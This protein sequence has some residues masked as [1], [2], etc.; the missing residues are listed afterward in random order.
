[1]EPNLQDL[2]SSKPSD[3]TMP[4]DAKAS[5]ESEPIW[6]SLSPTCAPPNEPRCFHSLQ[7]LQAHYAS[8]HAFV[9]PEEGCSCLFNSEH[10]LRLHRTEMHDTGAMRRK[11]AGESIYQCL[12]E[13]CGLI[14][15]SPAQRKKHLLGEHGFEQRFFFSVIK[16]GIGEHL[17]A[18]ATQSSDS[19]PTERLQPRASKPNKTSPTQQRS[20][21]RRQVH[22]NTVSNP[23][24]VNG[25]TSRSRAPQYASS[26]TSLT[27]SMSKVL[28]H[29]RDISAPGTTSMGRLQ[30]RVFTQ[31]RNASAPDMHVPVSDIDT[32]STTEE[33]DDLETEE[34]GE[35]SPERAGVR[36]A[37]EVAIRF[38]SPVGRRYD[39]LSR[40]R[41]GNGNGTGNGVRR[42][43]QANRGSGGG[44]IGHHSKRTGRTGGVHSDS[45]TS[46]RRV[47]SEHRQPGYRG[48]TRT[49]NRPAPDRT[50]QQQHS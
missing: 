1:M 6:C 42:G 44:G 30:R 19:Q 27:S 29:T 28:I 9:C 32:N 16:Y 47:F 37:E 36:F 13:D 20:E 26:M 46:G 4:V 39:R 24:T 2:R 14:F 31:N 7:D 48:R 17:R 23:G 40:S 18:W 49:R 12:L 5:L 3:Y 35:S 43:G 15:V 22:G 33:D 45:E 25:S 41:G 8:C 21:N 10:F 34:A 11:G 38:L 50:Q